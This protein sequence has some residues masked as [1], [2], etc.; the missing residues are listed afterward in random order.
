MASCIQNPRPKLYNQRQITLRWK[1]E[2]PKWAWR[3]SSC[4]TGRKLRK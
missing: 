4:Y 1:Q 2:D 3:I